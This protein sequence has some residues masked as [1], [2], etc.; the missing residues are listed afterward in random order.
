VIREQPARML[1][2]VWFVFRLTCESLSILLL[3]TSFCLPLSKYFLEKE[4]IWGSSLSDFFFFMFC[5]FCFTTFDEFGLTK[6]FLFNHHLNL[7]SVKRK[8]VQLR[9]NFSH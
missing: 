7:D 5:M 3:P 4:Q 2:V 1:R 9:N 6:L 8:L